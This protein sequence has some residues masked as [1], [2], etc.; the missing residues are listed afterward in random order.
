MLTQNDLNAKS[1]KD[2]YRKYGFDV[3]AK[4]VRRMFPY[5]SEDLKT[6]LRMWMANAI[7]EINMDQ[8]AAKEKMAK[9]LK[10]LEA[11]GEAS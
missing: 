3:G 8:N 11:K 10:K 9:K 4:A 1:I 6:K 5:C 7:V 2:I